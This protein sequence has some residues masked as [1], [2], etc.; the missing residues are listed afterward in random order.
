MFGIGAK[1]ES[2][3]IIDFEPI[4]GDQ[5]T[6]KVTKRKEGETISDYLKRVGE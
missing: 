6:Q 2:Y 3:N 5:D 4:D 1:K